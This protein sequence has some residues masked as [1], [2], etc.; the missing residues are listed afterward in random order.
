MGSLQTAACERLR[1]R[2]RPW[3]AGVQGGG[4]RLC[5]R[6]CGATAAAQ[7][8]AEAS[9]PKNTTGLLGLVGRTCQLALSDMPVAA[10]AARHRRRRRCCRRQP[11]PA[12]CAATR[13]VLLRVSHD[14]EPLPVLVINLIC[15]AK[16][17]YGNSTISNSWMTISRSQIDVVCGLDDREGRKLR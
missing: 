12:V 10:A 16:F 1:A 7:A 15:G 13:S 5:G 2:R 4:D 11:A 14:C 9:S 8:E 6:C 17:Q 3:L